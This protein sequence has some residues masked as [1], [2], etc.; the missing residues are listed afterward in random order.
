M[1]IMQVKMHPVV[2]SQSA[3]DITYEPGYTGR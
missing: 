2:G 1:Q 3:G